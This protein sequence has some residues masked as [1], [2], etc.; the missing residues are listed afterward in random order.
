MRQGRLLPA[1]YSQRPAGRRKCADRSEHG[2]H[3][4]LSTPHGPGG[5]QAHGVSGARRQAPGEDRLPGG[6]LSAP[7]ADLGEKQARGSRDMGTGSPGACCRP[8]T[9]TWGRS[10]PAGSR[11]K[12]AAGGTGPAGPEGHPPGTRRGPQGEKRTSPVVPVLRF[13]SHPALPPDTPVT[14]PRQHG[15]LFPALHAASATSGSPPTS[16]SFLRPGGHTCCSLNRPTEP[17]AGEQRPFHLS[18]Q[19][20]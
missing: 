9:L 10:R 12:A 13:C 5:K 11:N 17:C 6:P 2:R 4:S 14:P 8:R 20:Q 18:L 3:H 1:R 19:M 15:P 16:P 7:H